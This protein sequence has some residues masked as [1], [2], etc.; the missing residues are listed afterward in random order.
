MMSILLAVIRHGPTEW[1]ELGKIQ[2]RTD[3]PLSKNGKEIIKQLIL[4]SVLSKTTWLTSPL[5]RARETGQLLG[6]TDMCIDERL[7]ETNWG[8]WEGRTLKDLRNQ[9]GQEM[10]ENEKKGL[11]LMPPGGESPRQVS[12]RLQPLL[13]EFSQGKK[14]TNIGAITHKGVIRSL[15]SLA[16]G[17]DMSGKP[18]I[19][20]DWK[21][22]HIF[23]IDSNGKIRPHHF[24]LKL[25]TRNFIS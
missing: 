23:S 12:C 17:W 1:N 4:P 5:L 3:I 19:K 8:N 7:I 18:P 22:A 10:I 15:L 2:G 13:R 14:G 9:Y 6:I 20:L 21:A 24:N 11:D 16:T 25:N